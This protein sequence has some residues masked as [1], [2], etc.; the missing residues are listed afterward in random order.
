VSSEA[1][2][3]V[4]RKTERE[5]YR[6]IANTHYSHLAEAVGHL[7]HVYAAGCRFG[8]LLTTR[9]REQF[10]SHTAEVLVADDLLSRG[11]T[12][13]TIETSG[14]VSPDLHVTGH[15][16]DIAVEVYSRRGLLAVDRGV[17]GVKDLLNNI[18]IAA[19][20]SFTV[21][22]RLDRSIPPE[23]GQLDPWAPDKMLAQTGE[24]VLAEIREDVRTA[25]HEL[26]PLNKEYPHSGTSLVTAVVLDEVQQSSNNGPARSGSISSPGFGGYSPAGIF[27]TIVGA[28]CLDRSVAL[29]SGRR[30]QGD[31]RRSPGP[32]DPHADR[33]HRD[34]ALHPAD[35]RCGL[36]ALTGC[37]GRCRA[38]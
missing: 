27:R 20:Y 32:G 21:D 4:L 5:V 35:G 30:G 12:V 24:E 22:T 7:E 29:P 6:W 3:D 25:L 13:R 11:Y 18:D 10:V 9:S 33:P 23:P 8:D 16:I 34:A 31:L 15:G 19:D 38:R 14:E 26:Q 36:R 17:D 1:W 28:A 2:P 37:R